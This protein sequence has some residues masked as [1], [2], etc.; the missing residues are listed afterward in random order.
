MV[1]VKLRWRIKSTKKNGK[2]YPLYYI[3]IPGRSAVFLL[4]YEPYL[5]PTNK[6]IV[7]KPKQTIQNQQPQ[8]Q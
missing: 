7:F 3:S 1:A 4:D 8:S 6:V 5:D 2:L